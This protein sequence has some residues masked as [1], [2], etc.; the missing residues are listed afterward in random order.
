VPTPA[1]GIRL[2]I[3]SGQLALTDYLNL[4]RKRGDEAYPLRIHNEPDNPEWIASVASFADF[5]RDADMT[6]WSRPRDGTVDEI[7]ASHVLEHFGHQ[8]VEKVLREWV[9]VLKP[10]GTIR[11][12]VPNLD[13]WVDCY[14]SEHS[15]D[16][17]LVGYLFGGQADED[18]YHKCPFNAAMLTDLMLRCGLGDIQPW[19]SEIADCAR[20]PVSLNLQGVK[21]APIYPNL[22]GQVAAC[23]SVPRFGPLDTM[24]CAIDTFTKLNIPAIRKSGAFWHQAL[25]GAMEIQLATGAKY[26]LCL[27]YDS[28]FTADDVLALY[29]LMEKHPEADAI[30]PIQSGRDRATPLMTV[31]GEDGKAKSIL[32]REEVAKDL[33]ELRSGHFGCS[34]IRAASMAKL[35]K[36]WFQAKPDANGSWDEGRVDSDT[37][38]WIN[39]RESGLRLF[40]ANR[41][42]IGHGQWMVSFPDT[43]LETRHIYVSE[44]LTEGKPDWVWR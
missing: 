41:I 6:G 35:S 22:R 32:S 18:D 17:P 21:G 44:Y 10:G 26:L 40:Q 42:A 4:D 9:R 16:Y 12:A 29:R 37:F 27:D 13:W 5:R 8:Q 14:R 15:A 2:N 24:F 3:G 19:E 28:I 30:C 33:L 34:M 43:S 23:F 20:L 7:R 1:T 36:P 25:T 38:F 31:S 11:I 39:F